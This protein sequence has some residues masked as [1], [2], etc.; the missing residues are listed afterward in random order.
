MEV[1]APVFDGAVLATEMQA[2]ALPVV[3]AFPLGA[4]LATRTFD[5]V[6]TPLEKLW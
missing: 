1:I 6:Y 3:R 4:V 2:C 5:S